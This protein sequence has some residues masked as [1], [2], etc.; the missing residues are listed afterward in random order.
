MLGEQL[1][2]FANRHDLHLR[3][4]MGSVLMDAEESPLGAP[5]SEFAD[6]YD[7]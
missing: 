1:A 3:G 5:T 4:R 2:Q 6:R 7:A